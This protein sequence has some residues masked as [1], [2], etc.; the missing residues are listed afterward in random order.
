MPFLTG[1]RIAVVPLVMWIVIPLTA[2]F[3][4]R[5]QPLGG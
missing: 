1:T 5:R 2:L 3:L 4:A